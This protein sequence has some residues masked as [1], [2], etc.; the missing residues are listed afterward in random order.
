[1]DKFRL[2][3]NHEYSS[4]VPLVQDAVSIIEADYAYLYG[5]DDLADRLEI[6]K[7][8]LIR[9]FTANTGI[10]P[11]KYLTH[12]RLVHAK[13]ILQTREDTPLEIIAGAC[14]YS[15]ANYFCKAF[16][17]QTGLTPSEY[18]EAFRRDPDDADTDLLLQKLYL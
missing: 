13:S 14:G 15:C 2:L 3:S 11:G 5:I 6:T 10:S 16:K 7:H 1:M 18:A 4:Y 9:V 12:I 17:K 8:H